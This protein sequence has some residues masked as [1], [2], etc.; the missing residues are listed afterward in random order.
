MNYAICKELGFKTEMDLIKKEAESRGII[1]E[2]MLSMKDYI[3][4]RL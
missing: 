2:S 1:L 3:L 4:A